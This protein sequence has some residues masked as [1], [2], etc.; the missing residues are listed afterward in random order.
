M[1]SFGRFR[2]EVKD[3]RCGRVRDVVPEQ[4]NLVLD[5]IFLYDTGTYRDLYCRLGTGVTAPTKGDSTLANDLGSSISVRMSNTDLVD[6]RGEVVDGIYTHTKRIKFESTQGQF[7]GNISEIGISANASPTGM[8]TRALIKDS[9]GQPTT[10]TLGEFDVL[11]VYYDLGFS[12]NTLDPLIKQETINIG[13]VSTTC[14]L[15]W[16]GFS[17]GKE[18]W[19]MGDFGTY[20]PYTMTITPTTILSYGERFYPFS[21]AVTESEMGDIRALIS[22]YTSYYYANRGASVG[23][24]KMSMYA[25]SESAAGV[26]VGTWNGIALTKGNNSPDDSRASILAV[27]LFDPP[28][29]KGP[30][31]LFKFNNFS[32]SVKGAS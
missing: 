27:M 29:V 6:M 15:Y 2:I 7:I 1:K 26:D 22:S 31:D 30:T 4:D 17:S 28:L 9:L 25:S 20:A 3:I 24:T 23:E 11:T 21:G 16:S 8:I 32:L 5:N 18:P 10:L 13:G 14:S 12:I 19:F